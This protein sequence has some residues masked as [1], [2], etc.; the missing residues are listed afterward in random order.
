M[1]M[2][3]RQILHEDLGCA[4]YIIASLGEAAVVDPK[5]EIGE[6][7]QAGEEAGAKIRHVLETHFHADHVSGRPRLAAATGAASL[8]PADPERPVR[9]ILPLPENANHPVTSGGRW[10]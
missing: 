3:F 7:L 1:S 5:W 8:V 9:H 10:W 4:S 2:F 6:Y